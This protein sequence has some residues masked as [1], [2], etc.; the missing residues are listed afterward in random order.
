MKKI[1]LWIKSYGVTILMKSI[2]QLLQM[3][4]YKLMVTYGVSIQMKDTEQYFPVAL[5]VT[6]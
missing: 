3:A 4:V 5:F 6:L 1:C 2:E